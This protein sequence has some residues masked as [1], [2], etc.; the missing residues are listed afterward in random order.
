M[1]LLLSILP[2]NLTYADDF[3]FDTPLKLYDNPDGIFYS[4]CE[5]SGIKREDI[6][7]A[8]EHLYD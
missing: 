3:R 4:L 6:V 1:A 2:S 7:N 5:R 8:A